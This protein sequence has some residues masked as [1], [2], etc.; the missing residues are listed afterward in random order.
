MNP[1]FQRI[2][3]IASV[4]IELRMARLQEK[5]SV[6]NGNVQS[7]EGR[8]LPEDSGAVQ[9]P[10][11]PIGANEQVSPVVGGAGDQDT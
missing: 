10:D 11:I 4:N 2:F 6:N 3:N 8:Q 5:W 7:Q 9:S 1:R